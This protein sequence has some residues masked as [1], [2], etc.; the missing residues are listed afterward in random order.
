LTYIKICGITNLE[1]ARCAVDAGA[2]MLGFILYP[3]SPRYLP[4]ERIRDI[5]RS[6]RDTYGLRGPRFVGVF[7][8]EPVERVRAVLDDTGL[9]LSQLSGDESPSEV[10]SLIPRAFKGIRPQTLDDARSAVEAYCVPALDIS[11]LP[12][13]L[14]DGYH[15]GQFGG[16]GL[17]ADTTAAQWLAS[18]VRLVLAGGLSPESVRLAVRQIQPWGVDVSSGVER[19]KGIKDHARVRAFV[20][21]VRAADAERPSG[22]V[23]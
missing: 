3:P 16:T 18:Q 17:R 20:E 5:V 8:N 13:L 7:V 10:R 14:V 22:N 15:P 1:D 6:V 2:D 11:G 9:D 12:Q 23:I 19:A 21:T 4:P